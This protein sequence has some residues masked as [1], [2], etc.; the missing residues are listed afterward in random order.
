MRII[1][2]DD[3]GIENKQELPVPSPS[4]LPS[5]ADNEPDNSLPEGDEE[6]MDDCEDA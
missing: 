1:W 5:F 2:Q 3:Q 6:W 4:P